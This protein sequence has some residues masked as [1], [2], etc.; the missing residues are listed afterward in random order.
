M[1]DIFSLGIIFHCIFYSLPASYTTRITE[2]KEKAQELGIYSNGASKTKREKFYNLIMQYFEVY[3]LKKHLC[4]I[5]NIDET[6]N[7][8]INQLI[9]SMV[10]PDH[11]KRISSL[12][13]IMEEVTK[14]RAQITNA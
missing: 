5:I 2:L 10:E 8:S 1:A 13:T 3:E 12:D 14:I 6:I 7:E 4:V 11:S 9:L